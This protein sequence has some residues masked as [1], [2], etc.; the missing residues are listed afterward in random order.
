MNVFNAKVMTFRGGIATHI[1]NVQAEAYKFIIKVRAII[2]M[3]FFS[4]LDQI[5]KYVV[6]KFGDN[7]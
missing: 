3:L 2:L 1:S 4:E 7:L 6:G 5:E